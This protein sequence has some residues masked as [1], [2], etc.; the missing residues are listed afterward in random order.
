MRAFCCKEGVIISKKSTQTNEPGYATPPPTAA[1]TA[2]QGMVGSGTDF[3]TPI[4]NQFSRAKQNLN[5]SYN[6]PLG[7]YTTADVKQKSMRSQ[8]RDLD[9]N[10][11]I[12]LGDA[13]QRSQQAQFG[14][15]ATVAGLTSPQMYNAK[16]TNTVS[17][18]WGTGLQIAGL[19]LGGLSGG[20][21][22]SAKT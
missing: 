19:G 10:L 9:Q 8:N 1:T 22:G 21:S 7:A 2:L 6:N 17:D 16:S 4:R 12:A 13:A 11:G 3:Q 18:P 20:L 15:Q 5:D 14:Q